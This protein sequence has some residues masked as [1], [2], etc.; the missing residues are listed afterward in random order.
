MDIEQD[1]TLLPLTAAEREPVVLQ[2]HRELRSA[3]LRG[4][5]KAGMRMVETQLSAQ[6]NVSRTPVREAI[7][8]L[9]AEGLV[10][11]KANG[12]VV[13]VAF[14]QKMEEVVVIRQSLESAAVH[15]ACRNGS[16]EALADILRDCREAM[17]ADATDLASRSQ[18]DRAFHIGIA[19]ASGSMRLRLLI[20]EFYEY[21]FAAMQIEPTPEERRL[22]EVHHLEIASALVQ[23]DA[24]GAEE[25]VR[26]H[27]AEVWRISCA[28]MNRGKQ[29]DPEGLT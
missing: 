3:I 21:S 5:L 16:D 18:R 1:D 11:R 24:I 17:R 8:R 6:L 15:L 4:R 23:R 26:A 10:T 27:F 2:V 20:E 19:E 29:K 14:G 22:L 28:H 25:T 7:S 12:G 9:E 13:V